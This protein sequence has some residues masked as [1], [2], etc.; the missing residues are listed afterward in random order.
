V[1]KFSVSHAPLC[2]P[3]HRIVS[4]GIRLFDSN[5]LVGK[6]PIIFLQVTC[7]NLFSGTPFAFANHPED[8]RGQDSTVAAITC[9]EAAQPSLVLP[10]TQGIDRHVPHH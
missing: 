2:G 7:Q 6:G 1:L 9:K 8:E 10:I 5:V 4:E 3:I